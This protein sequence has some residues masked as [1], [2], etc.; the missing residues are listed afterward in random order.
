[1]ILAVVVVFVLSPEATSVSGSIYS[2]ERDALRMTP[3]AEYRLLLESQGDAWVY[4][5]NVDDSSATL[6]F[7]FR[8]E[9]GYDYLGYQDARFSAAESR[10]VPHLDSG[11][12]FIVE[13]PTGA[14]E[15]F[16]VVGSAEAVDPTRLEDEL[17]K[18]SNLASIRSWLESNFV[19][20][21]Y[22]E[23]VVR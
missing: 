5:I 7:P 15:R 21:S 23:F 22:F 9:A 19:S 8:T 20:L 1:M 10:V 2:G 18:L 16:F 14:I 11:A 17:T 6:V 4:A 3:G 13:A 12:A